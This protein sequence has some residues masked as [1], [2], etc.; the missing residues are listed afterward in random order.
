MMMDCPLQLTVIVDIFGVGISGNLKIRTSN[1]P[2]NPVANGAPQSDFVKEHYYCE[3]GVVGNAAFRP[4][5]TN[6]PL[7]D[8][9]GCKDDCCSDVAMTWFLYFELL[10]F[11]RNHQ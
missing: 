8:G 4:Y 2:C 11:E 3:S 1:C 9:E 6:D 5:Y 7:W 10:L